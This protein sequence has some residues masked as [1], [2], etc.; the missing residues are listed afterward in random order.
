MFKLEFTSIPQQVALKLESA[1]QYSEESEVIHTWITQLLSGYFSKL[2]ESSLDYYIQQAYSL[3]ITL[4]DIPLDNTSVRRC[5][6]SLQVYCLSRM[7]CV[8][9]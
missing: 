9:I 1:L 5:I 6:Q 7:S 3:F 2:K 4:N 8:W